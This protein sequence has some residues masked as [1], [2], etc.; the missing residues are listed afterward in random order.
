MKTSLKKKTDKNRTGNKP[1]ILNTWEKELFTLLQGDTNPVISKIPGAVSVGPCPSTSSSS[2]SPSSNTEFRS[3]KLPGAT[4]H[5]L[6][7]LDT[8]SSSPMPSEVS[9]TRP[10]P[11]KKPKL[12]LPETEETKILS[13]NDLHR[14]VLLEQLKLTRIQTEKERMIIDI[15]NQKISEEAKQPQEDRSKDESAKIY[16]IL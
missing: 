12:N 8:R 10:L 6:V 2:S 7:P 4:N 1:I 16:T 13:T 9:F 11:T 15:L 5:P 3:L 14:L